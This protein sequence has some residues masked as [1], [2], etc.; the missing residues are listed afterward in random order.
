MR[1]FRT[2]LPLIACS[3]MAIAE[4]QL[5]PP[6]PLPHE[7]APSAAAPVAVDPVRRTKAEGLVGLLKMDVLMQQQIEL[8]FTGSMGPMRKQMPPEMREPMEKGMGEVK[9]LMKQKV[10]WDQLKGSMIDAYATAFTAD[11]LDQLSTFYGSPL[12]Q[13]LVDETP[14][15]AAKATEASQDKVMGLMPEIQR[16]MMKHMSAARPKQAPKLPDGVKTLEARPAQAPAPAEPKADA[17][18]AP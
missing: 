6:A 2:A 12:G 7:I 17:K 15:L 13:R 1:P 4:E 3:F 9:E 16:I 14:R 10:S 18:A 8:G 5:P 11:E